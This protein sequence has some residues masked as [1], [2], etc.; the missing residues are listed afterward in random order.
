MIAART[1]VVVIGAGQAGLS[2]AFHLQRRGLAYEMFDA[3]AGPGGAWRH[4]W[5][6]LRMGTV[7]GISDLP[8][9]AKPAVDPREPSSE[10]L[11]RYFGDYEQELGLT[12][13]RPVK[14]SSVSREDDDPAG[15]LRVVTSIGDWSARALINAT[16]TWTRPF[17]PIYPGRN[18][19]RGRQLHVADYVSA[20]EFLGKHVI[21]VGGGVSAVG[22][23]DEISQVTS[24]SWFTRR[25]PVWRDD[26]FDARAGHDA[27]ALVEERVRKGLPPQSVVSVTGLIRTPALRA[28]AARGALDRQ[29]MF[30]AIEPG[31]VRLADGGFLA[32]DAILWAT[33]F[34]AELEHLAPL[35]LRGPGG[36]IAMDGTQVAAE[37]RV[38]LVGYGPSSSTIGA[39]RAGR[40]AVAAILKLPGLAP[41]AEP[42]PWG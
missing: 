27:V 25:E 20:T 32:A 41:A 34:R 5:K 15:R 4:R 8:G 26:E 7:N 18:S 6:S 36:G 42:V 22:L 19:F 30:T 1:D 11:T 40:A 28:A 37:P 35:H 21:V 23:L 3:E 13:R 17:W 10:F 29:P 16:G 31:G 33:G 9:I 2:A 14:V 38:H 39:N 12:V 24:T